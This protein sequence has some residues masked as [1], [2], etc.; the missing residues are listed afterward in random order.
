MSLTTDNTLFASPGSV[1]IPLKTIEV[2]PGDGVV[3]SIILKFLLGLFAVV[4]VWNI[5]F[6]KTI[7]FSPIL[8]IPEVFA[9]PT[10][11]VYVLPIPVN[12]SEISSYIWLLS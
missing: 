8:P 12:W 1:L 2:I 7:P 5:P 6:I 3:C 4:G 11:I 10:V 9:P